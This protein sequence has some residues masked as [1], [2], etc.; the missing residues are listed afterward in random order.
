MDID[1]SI[2][3]AHAMHSGWSVDNHESGTPFDTTK[4][5]IINHDTGDVRMMTV[6]VE[7]LN[8]M[9]VEE[10]MPVLTSALGLAYQD[11]EKAP[12]EESINRLA[13][14]LVAYALKTDAYRHWLSSGQ[15]HS[16]LHFFIN[17][18]A[19]GGSFRPFIAKSDDK[20]ID[21]EL[22]MKQSI[23]VAHQDKQIHPEWFKKG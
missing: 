10:T 4:F 8:D 7:R 5:Y 11:Y 17:V 20:I 14:I 22:V 19:N 23:A 1:K 3:T 6:P 21:S 13:Q 9:E 12:G 18:Y 2:S 16:R 15:E